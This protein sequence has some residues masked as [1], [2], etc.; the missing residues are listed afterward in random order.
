M[1]V[2]IGVGL[3]TA[4]DAGRP[5]SFEALVDRSEQLGFDSLWLSERIGGPAPDPLVALA[6]AAGR[7]R[8]LK[9]G[10]SVL[11]VPGRNP[12][13]LAKAMAT[14][15][16]L[17]GGRF[18]PAVGLGAV[19]PVEQQAFG[20]ER[21]GR[22]ARLDEALTLMRQLWRGEPVTHHGEHFSVEGVRVLPT[23]AQ[24]HLDVWLGGIAP[25]ELR[26]VGRLGDGW[27]PSF[28]TPGDVADGIATIEAAAT[29][30]DRTIDPEHYGVLL[31][32]REGELP[33]RIVE[34]VTRRRPDLDP[35]TVIPTRDDVARLVGEHIDAGASKFVVMPLVDAV[36]WD[37]ELG[38]L[39][40]LLLPLET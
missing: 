5:G 14:L 29:E 35:R 30:A 25:S 10:T 22:G 17:S 6:V 33:E 40:E 1:K 16:V 11:V 32:Y 23:P 21:R 28:C 26:R 3:G 19:D 36:D 34:L 12:V 15:D 2:R 27:L 9:L 38:R 4:T 37:A 7:T 20:V 31:A 24:A 13:V 18:L 8:R 39:A